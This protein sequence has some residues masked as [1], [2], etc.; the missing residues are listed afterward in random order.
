ME[1]FRSLLEAEHVQHRVISTAL[2]RASSQHRI[3]FLSTVRN[4]AMQPLYDGTFKADFVVFLNDIVSLSS[5]HLV[6]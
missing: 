2:R 6:M 4:M 1:L 5:C 3:D